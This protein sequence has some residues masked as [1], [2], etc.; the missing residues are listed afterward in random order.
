MG[1]RTTKGTSQN[2]RQTQTQ[3]NAPPP[4]AVPLYA[5]GSVDAQE[6][7]RSGRG[8]NVYQ[9][10]R[11]ADLSPES[12]QAIA[13]LVQTAGG[14]NNGDLTRL[15][16]SPTQSERNLA[17]LAGGE[18]IGRNED[19]NNGLQNTL[20]KSATMINS[21]MSGAGRLGSG[22]HTQALASEL[23]NIATRARA[24]QYNRDVETMLA[25]NAQIDQ[26]NQNR[27]NNAGNFLARQSDAYRD[28]LAGGQIRDNQAQE[29]LD[30][31]R[32]RWLE[33]DNREWERLRLLQEA[34]NGFAGDYGT[35]SGQNRDFNRNN[36]GLVETLASLGRLAGKR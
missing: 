19:F 34:A 5:Q 29:R 12:N 10:A 30:A 2:R 25:A 31:D 15:A 24:D 17:T 22:A 7:Y 33:N 14:F 23:G 28:A 36:P 4:W 6:L 3:V 13:G 20:E 35:R 26:A 9:G 8:G 11:V 18:R 27:L 32:Q 16:L 21:R 1:G